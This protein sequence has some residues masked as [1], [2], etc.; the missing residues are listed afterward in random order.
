MAILCNL[1]NIQLVFG[2]KV[3]FQ[4]AGLTVSKGDKIGLIGLNGQGKSTLF[5][6]LT[7]EVIPDISTP[8][9]IF[10][11]SKEF[12]SVFL[13]PQE[14]PIKEFANLN[15]KNFYL[16]FYPELYS[17]HTK[18]QEV[19]VKI[20]EGDHSDKT[21]HLQEKLLH[22]FEVAGGW[23][24]QNSYES[25]LKKFG[26]NDTS[27]TLGNLSG[28]EQKKMA[29]SAGLSAPHEFILWD[30][31]TNHLDIESIEAFEDELQN[32]NK[33]YMVISH[34]RYLLNHVSN[35][36]FHIDQGE[37][38]QFHGT[39][40]EYLEYQQ[41]KEQ[42]RLKQLDKL[43][44]RHRRELAWMRQGIKARGTRSKKR[45]EGFHNI[46]KDIARLKGEAKREMQLDMQHS[47]RKTKQLV[48][49]EDGQFG[50]EFPILTNL[51]LGIFKKDKIA[52]IGPNGAGK[53]TL[54]NLLAAN[55]QLSQGHYKAAQD[56]KT[57]IFDQ[58]RLTLDESKTP[59]EVVG[60]G[61]DH[62]ITADGT[63]KHIHS[64]LEKFLFKDHQINRPISTLSGGEKNRL[65]LAM[66]M[67]QQADL[68]IFDEPTNDLD[69]ETIELLER[70][71]KAY[72]QA[73]IIIGHDRAFL[74][75]VVEHTWLI[76]NRQVEIFTGG[77]AQVAPY[78][79]ALEMEKELQQSNPIKT[80]EKPLVAE[81]PKEKMTNKEK[82]RWKVIEEEI[83]TT[84]SQLDEV[85]EKLA[86]FDF[87]TVDENT[88]K[89]Y[90][91]LNNLSQQTE[92]RLEELYEEWDILSQ[93][94]EP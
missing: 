79:H 28:G 37:I 14:L 3:I 50:Y 65:Q 53:T 75:N 22:D 40:L 71:L 11:K 90:D 17:L 25:Y 58:K 20:V 42:E 4:N 33:S 78:L 92:S 80:V 41:E 44:N 6:I 87:T 7:G 12:F 70:E 21:L 13:V 48:H 47:G 23:N 16:A 63:Q 49:I 46:E 19:E 29:L 86:S 83:A 94:K 51:N 91:E 82:M 36:I 61:K 10:D 43:Q 67:L 85:Q 30:E 76:H 93:K 26:I 18:L 39:Y 73:V 38:T 45:V 60:D 24:I 62:V 55:I 1:Q 35:K 9:F 89:A 68:W 84:E 34:D 57:V 15:V 27:T 66:F 77:Y 72:N 8:P 59:K 64:Y 56:L 2:E 74:D 5:K 31:P 32:S 81:S 69:I 52:I 88:K 54:V